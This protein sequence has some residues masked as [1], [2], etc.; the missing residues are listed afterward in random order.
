MKSLK[1]AGALGAVLALAALTLPASGQNVDPALAKSWAFMQ[2]NMPGVP[3]DLLASACDEGKV[4][5]YHGT[6]S[7]AQQNQKKAFEEAFPC[8]T[9]D[10]FEL[11]AGILRQRFVAESQA[12]QHTADIIQDSD[13]GS[14][15]THAKA[16]LLAEYKITSDAAF[17]DGAKHSGVWY[18]LR[19]GMVGIA[20]NTDLVTD[21]E[22][23]VL[24]DWSGM[25]D[26]RWEGRVGLVG[27][28]TGGIVLATWYSWYKGLGPDVFQRIAAVKPRIFPGTVPSA[29]ALAS[30]DIAVLYGASET[31]LL[32]LMMDG[33]P[34][35]WTL[36][37]PAIGPLSG[38]AISK[39]APHPSAARLYH[40]YAFSEEGYGAWQQ[41]GGAPARTNFK[42]LREVVSKPWYHFPSKFFDF[43]PAEVTAANADMTRLFEQ[44]V[45]PK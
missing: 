43:P 24:K 16:G 23:A 11:Q 17:S 1:L 40:E 22:A 36:P 25:F 19:R 29:A 20:W 8:V 41:L 12:G 26:K 35:K 14:L 31:G 13:V 9:V 42:D 4:T 34:V 38:Q 6:W 10:L 28:A 30:G 21:E 15:D 2:E 18:P 32:P 39:N 5:I 44:Y 27:P 3:Y 7:A 33:A 45:V 37:E